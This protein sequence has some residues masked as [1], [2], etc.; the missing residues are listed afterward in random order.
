MPNTETVKEYYDIHTKKKLQDFVYG[1]ARVK[2]AYETIAAC[3]NKDVKTILEIGCGIGYIANDIAQIASVEKVIGFDISPRSVEIACRLFKHEKLN[4]V[5]ADSLAETSFAGSMQ[6]DLIVLMDVYEHISIEE[7]QSFNAQLNDFLSP[8]GSVVL[9]C[10]TPAYL[11]WLRKNE[12]H[13]IQPV[14]ENIGMKELHDLMQTTSTDLLF[15]KKKNIWKQGDYFHACLS[16]KTFGELNSAHLPKSSMAQVKSKFYEIWQMINT[17]IR[18]KVNP[19]RERNER[20]ER[21]KMALG[22]DV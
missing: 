6:F 11:D 5:Q 7:R 15:Y 12:S 22:M 21:V 16:R 9:T 20:K 14:D 2:A 1:N 13:L 3:I 17:M 4:Y 18:K 19:Y 8:K 10:P